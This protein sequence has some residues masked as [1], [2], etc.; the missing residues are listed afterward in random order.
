MKVGQH[1]MVSQLLKGVSNERPPQPRC[2]FTWDVSKVLNFIRTLPDNK[3]LDFKTLSYKTLTLLAVC[4]INRS[5]E[6]E[7]INVKFMAHHEDYT[8]CGFGIR[9]KH[10]R[11]GKPT[12]PIFFHAFPSEPKVC[13]VACLRY[14]ESITKAAR[15]EQ[16]TS[17]FFLSTNKP[18]H[19]VTKSTLAGWLLKMLSR[20]GIDVNGISAHSVRSASSSKAASKGVSIKDILKQGNWSNE[21]V[22]QGFYHKNVHKED[23]PIANSLRASKTY[24]QAVLGD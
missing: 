17:G 7:G 5:K 15:T 8:Q 2:Y 22:W 9:V 1:P 11:R 20:A 19:P 24:Q 12:P 4:Q 6:L 13:P 10:R 3:E 18:H 14:Y 21:D 23:S 16:N